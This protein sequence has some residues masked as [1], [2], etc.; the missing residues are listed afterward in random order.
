MTSVHHVGI[1]PADMDVAL[2]F[3]RDG[4][5]LD[6][7]VDT[8]MAG[9]MESLLGVQTTSLR[10]IFL[11]NAKR[12]DAGIVELVDLKIPE[13]ASGTAQAGLPARGLFLLSFQV[14]VKAVL[15]RLAA[16]GVGGTPRTMRVVGGAIAATVTDPDGVMVEL[17]QEGRPVLGIGS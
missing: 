7:L 14:D 1:C 10:T 5:G 8:E 6:V 13:I 3:Y 17:L 15:E 11:G 2:R 9:D 12:P 4:L 16:M